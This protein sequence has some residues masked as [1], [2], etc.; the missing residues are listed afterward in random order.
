MRGSA[1][2]ILIV[3]ALREETDALIERARGISRF[4]GAP[5][6]AWRGTLSGQPV[7]LARTGAGPL[8]AASGLAELLRALGPRRWIGAGLAG[9]LAPD[10]A[11]GQVL[12]AEAV[13]DEEG[14]IVPGPDRAWVAR[15]LDFAPNARGARLVTRARIA[16]TA[17]EKAALRG[18]EGNSADAVD[19][20][21]AGWA[22][23]AQAA[24]PGAPYL[25]ARVVSD[26]AAEDLP[27]FLAGSL[28]AD[29][30]V[31]RGRVARRALL[32]PASIGKLLGLRRRAHACAG[33][34]AEFLDRFAAAGF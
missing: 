32:A 6:P 34:L 3:T 31:D 29:G 4:P 10:I 27:D 13:G 23:A 9:A 2:E 16:V 24:A 11:V 30:S 28:A 5:R 14:T 21:S 15:A 19:M 17:K 22:R 12:I 1:S 8:N 26:S 18:R 25:L 20:E 33:S 7:I